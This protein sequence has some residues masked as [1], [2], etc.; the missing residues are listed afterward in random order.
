MSNLKWKWESHAFRNLQTEIHTKYH[1]FFV[2]ISLTNYR[3]SKRRESG[4]QSFIERG[5]KPRLIKK[6]NKFYFHRPKALEIM[7]LPE[8]PLRTAYYSPKNM[9]FIFLYFSSYFYLPCSLHNSRQYAI[10][11]PILTS[12]PEDNELGRMRG[13]F[14][15][16][17]KMR[18]TLKISCAHAPSIYHQTFYF[19]QVTDI[20]HFFK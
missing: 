19:C 6:T 16:R 20:F 13:S 15:T 12:Q 1:F 11:R 17:K 9:P 14:Q 2:L 5:Y 4:I 3:Y 8:T 10:R 18:K 7:K